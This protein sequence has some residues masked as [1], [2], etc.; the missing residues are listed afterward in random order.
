MIN[1]LLLFVFGNLLGNSFAIQIK[2]CRFALKEGYPVIKCRANC[3]NVMQFSLNTES[4]CCQCEN[5]DEVT[6]HFQ[7]CN[8]T[9]KPV[10]MTSNKLDEKLY[11]IEIRD[12]MCIPWTRSEE[13]AIQC[14]TQCDKGS[15][16]SMSGYCCNCAAWS[17]AYCIKG[18]CANDETLPEN[19]N[20]TANESQVVASSPKPSTPEVTNEMDSIEKST[21]LVTEEVLKDIDDDENLEETRRKRRPK[22]TQKGKKKEIKKIIQSIDLL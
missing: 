7:K 22:K 8:W 12:A 21:E 5:N 10:W 13:G 4:G 16:F 15:N 19:S 20:T 3:E 14:L 11:K 6:C 18:K 9:S 1:F 2:Q 17:M